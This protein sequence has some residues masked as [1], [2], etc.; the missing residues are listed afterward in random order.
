LATAL[1]ICIARAGSGSTAEILTMS[2]APALGGVHTG[3]DLLGGHALQV[4]HRRRGDLLAL[5]D[6]ELGGDVAVRRGAW[7]L[8]T[9]PVWL[10]CCDGSFGPRSS[11][12]ALAV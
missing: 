2:V 9:W 11:T 8:F 10:I 4:L 3:Q 5:D 6:V 7:L 12:W 1:A